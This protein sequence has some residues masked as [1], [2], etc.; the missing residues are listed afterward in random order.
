MTEAATTARMP[1]VVGGHVDHGK[2]TIIGRLLADTGSLPEGKLEQVRETCA[3]HAKP[4][5]Y[6][7]LL[8]ALKDEQAQGITIDV[9][10]IFFKTKQR[11]YLIIDAPGHI[12]FL[13]NLVTGAARAE[14]ALLVI[15]AKEGIQENSRR[16]GY[17]MSMLGIRQIAVLVNKMDLAGY[18]PAVFDAIVTE[19]DAFLRRIGVEPACFIPV[20]GREGENIAIAAATMPWYGGPTVLEMLDKFHAAPD[21]VDRPFRM[22]VQGVYKFTNQGD[23]R[24]IVAGSVETGALQVGDEVVFYPSGKKSWVETI[25]AFSR[26]ASTRIVAGQAAGFT[27]HE[28]IYV[29]RGEIATRTSDPR[30]HVTTRLRV[31]LF[32]LGRS[33]FVKRKDYVLKL[34]TMRA[35]AR[36]ES[37]TRVIDAASLTTTDQKGHIERNDVAECVLKL[38][39]A[40]AFDLA[41]DL[42]P[43]GRFVIVDDYEIRGGGI[44][45]EALPD[46]EAWVREKVLL[47]NYKWE[48]STISTERRAERYG[49]RPTLLLVTGSAEADRK[50][51]AKELEARLFGEG[52]VVYFLGIGSV[53]YGVDADLARETANRAEHFR[54]L[55]EVANILLDAGVILIVSAAELTQED[56]DIIRTTVEPA[57]IETIWMGDRVTTNIEVDLH[58]PSDDNLDDA[59]HRIKGLLR[60]KGIVYHAW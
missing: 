24:R 7:F 49:Q 55:A 27:L 45:R 34:G 2:S 20:C 19:Y 22:P 8:D 44:V 13:K 56:L 18:E 3:R 16:H 53:L 51:L 6:A 40:I 9:A 47:R 15:D 50:G 25:E 26:P 41:E 23:D 42:A 52:K 28:Q 33:P 32:W 46:R 57:L 5:E 39:R 58:L 21:P 37:V 35:L 17:L 60:E 54:R 30:P 48:P 43:T 59:F 4:F 1:I 29:G 11:Q 38:N 10:R 14:A 31:S 12:E 36:L